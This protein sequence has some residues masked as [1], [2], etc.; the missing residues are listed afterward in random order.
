MSDVF[1]K[2]KRSEIMSAVRSMGNRTTEWRLRSRLIRGGVSGWRLNVKN[3]FGKPDFVFD[4]ARVAVFI[5][6]C[7]WHG[8][9]R[10]RTIPANN[11]KFWLHKIKRNKHRDFAVNKRLRKDGWLVMRFWE[12]K[13]RKDPNEC[14]AKIIHAVELRKY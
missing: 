8:C 11:R 12:H 14:F 10:C 5:D 6:G 2:R 3:L 9:R 7:F 4:E 1:T 13:I